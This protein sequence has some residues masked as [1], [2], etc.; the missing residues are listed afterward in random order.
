MKCSICKKK[1]NVGDKAKLI[2][3]DCFDKNTNR[4]ADLEAKFA[5]SVEI[6]NEWMQLNIEKSTEIQQL[7][8]QLAEERKKVVQEIREWCKE[9]F[10]Y[11]KLP[12]ELG[13]WVAV[14]REEFFN[15]LDQIERGGL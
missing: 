9:N 3:F 14:N 6:I 1:L 12:N 4:I 13:C 11:T 2:C 5:E 15:I 8:Q 10:D 7:K